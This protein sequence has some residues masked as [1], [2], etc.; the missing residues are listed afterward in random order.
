VITQE[1]LLKSK[2]EGRLKWTAGLFYMDFNEPFGLG[3]PGVELSSTG[4]PYFSVANSNSDVISIAGYFDAT[5]QVM[6][7]L[8][9]S[10]GI[11]YSH[12]E[13]RDAYYDVGY[14]GPAISRVHLPV[15]KGNKA[16]P[17]VVLRYTLDSNSNVY[18]SWARGDKSAI[19]NV[20]GAQSTPVLPEQIDAFELGYKYGRQGLSFDLSGYYYNY[21]NLQVAHYTET[22]SVVQNAAKARVFGFEAQAQYQ[23]LDDLNLSAGMAYTNGKYTKFAGSP[24]FTQCLDTAGCRTGAFYGGFI[25]DPVDQFNKNMIRS[26]E[27]TATLGARYTAPL[28]GGDATLS[29]NLYYSSKFFFDSSNQFF[30]KP[31]ATLNLRAEWTSPSGRYTIAVYGQNVTDTHYY[32]QVAP[33]NTGVGAVWAPPATVGGEFKL[34]FGS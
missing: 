7:D 24:F 12:D 10:A 3:S 17:R 30:Q 26:P 33:Y 20:G 4:G 27:F 29:G 11:R 19:Y 2:L 34:R 18:A 1:F 28:M 9:L 13:V 5:Y 16:A 25:L 22:A 8:Y 6:P 21:S 23:V 32:S 31:F 14:F 15:L